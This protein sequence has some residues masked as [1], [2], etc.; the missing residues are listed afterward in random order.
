VLITQGDLDAEL[1]YVV[2]EGE[3]SVLV[4]IPE[5][6]KTIKVILGDACF[7]LH[8]FFVFRSLLSQVGT[9]VRGDCFGELAL[10]T[11]SPRS[12]T[13]MVTSNSASIFTLE[14][15]D[16]Q[17]FVVSSGMRA[18]QGLITTN[19]LPEAPEV[20]LDYTI[21]PKSTPFHPNC[22]ALLPQPELSRAP[23]DASQA[24]R[25]R[26]VSAASP[27]SPALARFHGLLLQPWPD[28]LNDSL[29]DVLGDFLP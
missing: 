6:L 10:M 21:V 19:I 11:I 25:P 4:S 22:I 8:T 23:S 9:K 14:R 5:D 26:A 16:F 15:Q 1:F 29:V 28:A 18:G 17:H 7:G 27:G 24:A 20:S 13:V 2:G 12:A 3:C